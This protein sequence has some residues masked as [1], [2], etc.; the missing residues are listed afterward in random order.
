MSSNIEKARQY[1]KECEAKF[2]DMKRGG[3]IKKMT[4]KAGI[5]IAKDYFD[6]G[7]RMH[8]MVMNGATSEEMESATADLVRSTDLIT[9]ANQAGGKLP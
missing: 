7:H 6:A 3:S 4:S 2:M 5:R 1:F 8:A 9:D